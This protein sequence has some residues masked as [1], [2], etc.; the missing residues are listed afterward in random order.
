MSI[1]RE[2]RCGRESRRTKR[3]RS[4]NDEFPRFAARDR[5]LQLVRRKTR[6]AILLGYGGGE[7]PSRSCTRQKSVVVL[8]YRADFADRI[9]IPL[10]VAYAAR[11]SATC[12]QRRAVKSRITGTAIGEPESNDDLWPA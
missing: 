12:E 9:T 4:A 5:E 2:S 10:R 6:S 1:A 3:G 11:L 8:S 7:N